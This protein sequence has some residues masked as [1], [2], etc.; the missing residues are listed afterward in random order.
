[1]KKTDDKMTDEEL[2]EF[3][4]RVHRWQGAIGDLD[5]PDREA[6][7]VAGLIRYQLE[8]FHA[9]NGKHKVDGL[10][11]VAMA[12]LNPVIRRAVY[13]AL[14]A[15]DHFRMFGEGDL[16]LG[17]VIPYQNVLGTAALNAASYW[18]PA[19]ELPPTDAWPEE[20]A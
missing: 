11:D 15:I 5:N 8:D 12:K 10:D 20:Q 7:L 17:E 4:D 19:S 9:S 3:I 16:D 2:D 6:A 13:E 14:M 1:V 18:E